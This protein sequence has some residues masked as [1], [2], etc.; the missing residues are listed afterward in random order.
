[1]NMKN[2]RKPRIPRRIELKKKAAQFI[3]EGKLSDRDIATKLKISYDCLHKWKLRPE[4]RQLIIDLDT[5]EIELARRKMLKYTDRAVTAL[6]KLT[7]TK[8]VMVNMPDGRDENGEIKFRKEEAERFVHS[9]E[10][11]RKACVNILETV[12]SSGGAIY[13]RDSIKTMFNLFFGM[14]FV[15]GGMDMLRKIKSG[16]EKSPKLKG[17]EFGKIPLAQLEEPKRK[18]ARST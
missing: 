4:F 13:D 1:M 11:V 6:V 14:V 5:Q 12:F 2:T 17:V 8:K 7:E 15:H 9:D 3:W 18:H 16:L 10:T